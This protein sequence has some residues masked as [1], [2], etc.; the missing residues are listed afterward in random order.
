MPISATSLT[1]T[2]CGGTGGKG[3]ATLGR[4]RAEATVKPAPA[5][6]HGEWA[7]VTPG[8]IQIHIGGLVSA[9]DRLV[10]RGTRHGKGTRG[11]RAGR[12]LGRGMGAMEGCGG[13]I[14]LHRDG[15]CKVS[16]KGSGNR[17]PGCELK[18]NVFL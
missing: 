12:G 5:L 6:V 3:V 2:G 10:G 4:V 1:N 8:T 18:P 16:M 13:L 14:L 11:R 17:A 9:R 15:C 7:L